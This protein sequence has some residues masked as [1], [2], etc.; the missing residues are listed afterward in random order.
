MARRVLKFLI[1][2]F[3]LFAITGCAALAGLFSSGS[4]SSS[5]SSSAAPAT[6]AA[7]ASVPSIIDEVET[8]TRIGVLSPPA[9][10]DGSV[11]IEQ[12]V[13]ASQCRFH[14]ADPPFLVP[15]ITANKNWTFTGRINE[16]SDDDSGAGREGQALEYRSWFGFGWPK[17]QLNSWPLSMYT[18]SEMPR[19]YLEDR[20]G[21]LA[22]HV[23]QMN[24]KQS[25]EL[26]KN[27][28]EDSQKIQSRVQI[29]VSAFDPAKCA[30]EP[31]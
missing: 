9:L 24:P 16:A 5:A 15:T 30:P 31:R 14:T 29:L 23:Y 2:V 13:I 25:D 7:V 12:S 27:Y 18:L 22:D 21:M 4:S 1:T 28:I 6:G 10:L 8:S 26:T 11:P 3:S 20:I 19:V 17:Q